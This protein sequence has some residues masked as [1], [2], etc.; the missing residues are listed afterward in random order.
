MNEYTNIVTI[1]ITDSGL[2]TEE[3]IDEAIIQSRTREIISMAENQL[4]TE[5]GVDDVKVLSDQFFVNEKG[6]SNG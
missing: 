5:L 3:A 4:K 2:G 6:D 1:Q